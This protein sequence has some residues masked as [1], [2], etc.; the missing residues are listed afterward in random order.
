MSWISYILM[1]CKH[2]CDIG[3]EI[4]GSDA[5]SIYSKGKKGD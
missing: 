1:I 5:D 3:L 2:E 4:G